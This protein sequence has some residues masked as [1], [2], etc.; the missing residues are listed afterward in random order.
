M[1]GAGRVCSG[2]AL[3]QFASLSTDFQVKAAEHLASSPSEPGSL[4]EAEAGMESQWHPAAR[5]EYWRV[6]STLLV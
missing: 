4:D 3:Q 1:S 5:R 6:F 2:L